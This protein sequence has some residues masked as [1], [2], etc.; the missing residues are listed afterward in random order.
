MQIKSK[1]ALYN[2]K[3]TKK[4]IIWKLHSLFL[5]KQPKIIT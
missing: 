3:I 1:F 2:I 5:K 4:G